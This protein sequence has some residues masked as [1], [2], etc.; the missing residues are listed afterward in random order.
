MRRTALITGGSRGLGR[1]LAL[2]LAREGWNV[3]IDARDAEALERARAEVDAA[4]PGDVVALPG[5]VTD[6][7]HV[8]ALVG[9]AASEG[10]LELLV[11]NAGTLGPSPL[12]SLAALRADDLERTLRTNLVAPLRLVQAA[13]PH[14][15]SCGGA[16][17]NV[18]SDAAVEGYPGWGAYGA[19]K[20]AL[21]QLS[22]V[23]AAEEP[24]IRVW[25][26]DPG[27][28]RTQMHQD[29]F[30]GEDISDRPD[31]ATRVPALLRLVEARPPSGRYTVDEL[32]PAATAT[33]EAA[34]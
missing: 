32:A 34:R 23:L 14:L 7:V 13:L 4:G 20:A 33:G 16:V 6:P 21:E 12:P 30:P 11:N 25:W 8:A 5:D 29:A 24:T 27:D 1:A 9:A 31:P 10:R 28:M 15:R 18:T 19:S 17:L 2:G 22:R 3:V 26:V